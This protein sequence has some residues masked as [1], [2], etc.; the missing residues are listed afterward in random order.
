[1]ALVKKNYYHFLDQSNTEV[2]GA[3]CRWKTL[4]QAQ[5]SRWSGPVSDRA[6]NIGPSASTSSR[7]VEVNSPPEQSMTQPLIN[8]QVMTVYF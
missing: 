2:G 1:M 5:T 3:G 8:L 4:S 7:V 6:N